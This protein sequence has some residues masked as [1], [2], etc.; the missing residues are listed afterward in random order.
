MAT[1][2]DP[3]YRTGVVG[4]YLNQYKIPYQPPGWDEWMVPAGM[5][6][7][8]T[9]RWWVNQGMGGSFREVSGYQTDVIGP[10]ASDFVR[11]NAPRDEPF[12]L[13]TN[14]VAPHAGVPADPDDPAD[15]PS[16]YVKPVYRDRFQCA[17]NTDPSFNE[18]DVSDKP[19]DTPPLTATQVAGL[20][21]ALQQRRESL[22]SAQDA[23][24][25]VMNALAAS[26]ELDNTFVMVT[27]D[28]G[29][30]LGEHRGIAGKIVPFEVSNHI[31]FAVRGPGVP[32]GTVV[33]TL[34]A[35][36]DLAA[37]VADIADVTPGLVQDG[38]SLL[39]LLTGGAATSRAGV[40]LEA[41]DVTATSD[42][43]PWL[44]RGVVKGRWKYV[45]HTVWEPE[46]YDLTADPHELVNVAGRAEHAVKL[47]EL[48]ALT[49]RLKSCAGTGCR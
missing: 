23:I 37:T 39:P 5:Y 17:T 46:L 11:R 43:L 30:V 9:P 15:T 12:F 41:T 36:V 44:Y 22:L 7:Y 19:F 35:Q 20:T 24:N 14:I 29:Y 31:P 2:L 34:T 28:N 26:G 8:L 25:K 3:T 49:K 40:L 45:E 48:A 4:K 18:A 16:P 42:P 21:E 33:P 13:Y 32:A 6:N 10:L 27:S 38:V 1:W 47:A